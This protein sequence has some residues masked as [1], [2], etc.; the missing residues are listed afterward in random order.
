MGLNSETNE[1]NAQSV[2]RSQTDA[3]TGF[4][5]ESKERDGPGL[6]DLSNEEQKETYKLEV[7]KTKSTDKNDKK[8]A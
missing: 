4:G 8:P 1:S 3:K 7:K 6:M 2:K 5:I